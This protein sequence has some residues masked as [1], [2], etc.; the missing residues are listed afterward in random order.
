MAVTFAIAFL[1]SPEIFVE[2]LSLE[3]LLDEFVQDCW[4]LLHACIIILCYVLAGGCMIF[5]M[6]QQKVY[7]KGCLVFYW[8][9]YSTQ[10]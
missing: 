8:Y 10:C 9:A 1:S 4:V 3:L 6:F 7:D 5:E 2:L